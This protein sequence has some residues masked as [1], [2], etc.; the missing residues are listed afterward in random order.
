VSAASLQCRKERIQSH[1]LEKMTADDVENLPVDYVDN[2]EN[3][4]CCL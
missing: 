1:E 2:I 3:S 4:G